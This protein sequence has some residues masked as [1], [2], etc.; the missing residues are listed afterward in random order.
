MTQYLVLGM[1]STTH[2]DNLL[3]T[4]QDIRFLQKQKQLMQFSTLSWRRKMAKKRYR[5]FE[6]HFNKQTTEEVNQ[7]I[8]D[9]LIPT[10]MWDSK[11]YKSMY[12]TITVNL[13]PW[14]G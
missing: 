5:K 10:D 3:I 12:W 9:H 4:E 11:K 8:A 7:I 13:Q 1:T 2:A 6:K 14:E